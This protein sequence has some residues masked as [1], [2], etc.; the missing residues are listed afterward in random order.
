MRER[1]EI[2]RGRLGDAITFL[3]LVL[4]REHEPVQRTA[5]IKA[6]E[7]CIEL[8]WRLLKAE[9]A[10]DGIDSTSPRDTIR[11]AGASNRIENVE[12]WLGY[13]QLRNMSSHTYAE[14]TAE[15]LYAAIDQQLLADLRGLIGG[16]T[17]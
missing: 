11:K 8:G 15:E 2:L 1:A 6:F 13:I 7:F 12:R 3:E 5:A 4:A 10:I 16:G 9:L 14:K 17:A